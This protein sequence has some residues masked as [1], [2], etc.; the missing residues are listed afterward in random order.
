MFVLVVILIKIELINLLLINVLVHPVSI[1]M[2][3][4]L[5]KNAILNVKHVVYLKRVV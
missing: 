3:M 1:Q 2:K 5:A 4:K